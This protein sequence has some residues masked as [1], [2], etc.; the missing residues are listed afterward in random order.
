MN[1]VNLRKANYDSVREKEKEKEKERESERER[2]AIKRVDI[3]IANMRR[4]LMPIFLSS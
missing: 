2:A 4:I 1:V 3:A